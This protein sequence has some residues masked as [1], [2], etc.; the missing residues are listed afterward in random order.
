MFK[1]RLAVL[2]VL[3]AAAVA[4]AQPPAAAPR[5]YRLT[6]SFQKLH[7]GKVTTHKEYVTLLTPGESLPAIRD[8]ASF[9]ASATDPAQLLRNNADVDFLAFRRLRNAVHVVLRISTETFNSDTP[10]SL[11]K[12]PVQYTHQYLISPTV[13]LGKRTV[14][15]QASD[16]MH[17]SKVLVELLIEPGDD[18]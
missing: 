9:R 13:L 5:C 7:D 18:L 16:E 12:L 11:P 17:H 2:S 6:L 10:E 1:L 8:D 4:A 14:V 3:F 15:Y